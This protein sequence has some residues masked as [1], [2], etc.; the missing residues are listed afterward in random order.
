VS[1]VCGLT[2][3]MSQRANWIW[4]RLRLRL[5]LDCVVQ[6]KQGY[7]LIRDGNYSINYNYIMRDCPFSVRS[8]SSFTETNYPLISLCRTHLPICY[9]N[10]ISLATRTTPSCLLSLLHLPFMALLWPLGFKIG[11]L[12]FIQATSSFLF[13]GSLYPCIIIIPMMYLYDLFY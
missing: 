6:E 8:L 13:V 10:S 2:D 1:C 11:P 9:S 5:W 4:G 3:A 7:C 12:N